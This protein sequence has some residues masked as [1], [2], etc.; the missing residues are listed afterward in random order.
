[1]SFSTSGGIPSGGTTRYNWLIELPKNSLENVDRDSRHPRGHYVRTPFKVLWTFI[2]GLAGLAAYSSFTQPFGGASGSGS[3]YPTLETFSER[4]NVQPKF[5]DVDDQQAMAI[6]QPW[7]SCDGSSDQ[8]C[9]TVKVCDG[10]GWIRALKDDVNKSYTYIF[11]INAGNA[12]NPNSR[13]PCPSGMQRLFNAL[14]NDPATAQEALS[15][16]LGVE[17]NTT[18]ESYTETFHSVLYDI[19][20]EKLNSA[21][22]KLASPT[23]AGDLSPEELINFWSHSVE[24]VILSKTNTRNAQP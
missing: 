11:E 7:T 1:M 18:A 5:H 10:N 14:Y 13:M 24:I 22:V 23:F 16:F 21:F 17:K 2:I 3:D 8:S 12:V 9:M 15:S 19:N 6:T 20:W 4:W